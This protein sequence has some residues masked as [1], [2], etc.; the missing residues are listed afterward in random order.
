MRIRNVLYVILCALLMACQSAEEKRLV[1]SK[2]LPYELLLV[3]ES[4]VWNGDMGD[5]LR[6]VFEGA[7]P[8]LTQYEPM[9]R[10]LRVFPEHYDRKYVTMRNKLYVRIDKKLSKPVLGVTRNAEAT[11]QIEVTLAARDVKELRMI[12]SQNKQKIVDLFVDSELNIESQRLRKKYSKKVADEVDS[13]FGWKLYASEEI[14]ASKK[15]VDF[16][17]AGTN[18]LEKDLNVVVY[19][20]PM[21]SAEN[22]FDKDVFVRKRDSVLKANIPGSRPDQWMT[23]TWEEGVPLV[24]VRKRVLDG[25]E[26]LEARGLWEMRNGAIGGPFVSLSRVD[27]AFERIAVCEGFVYSPRTKKRELIRTLE[28][29]LRT[30]SLQKKN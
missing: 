20:Y 25:S 7:M 24:E 26:V 3:V 4:E 6:S 18:R 2:G 12:F 14:K 28:A 16:L 13:I 8:G 22:A 9:F 30:L 5:S 1:K 17:W 23:T 10:L 11:P 27:S 15:G 21:N 19:T 29:A